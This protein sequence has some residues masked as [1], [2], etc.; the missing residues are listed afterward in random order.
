LVAGVT[1][2][3]PAWISVEALLR[4]QLN[5]I[6]TDLADPLSFSR[7]RA[8]QAARV[9]HVPPES[10]PEMRALQARFYPDIEPVML[11]MP[12]DQA[13]TIIRKAVANLGWRVVE[14]TPPSIRQAN[15]RL[16]AIALSPVLRLPDDITIRVRGLPEATRVDIRSTSR[17]GR[18]DM[19]TNAARIARFAD[20]LTLLAQA[21]N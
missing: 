16:E 9:G 13:F 15:G 19:G 6:I 12:A 8:A 5:D 18:H 10:T 21:R 17:Y 3:Y 2:A 1:L 14:E 4:P 20:E 11:D 7:S